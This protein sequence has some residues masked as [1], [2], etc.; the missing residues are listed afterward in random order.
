MKEL[1]VNGNRSI[2]EVNVSEAKSQKSKSGKHQIVLKDGETAVFFTDNKEGYGLATR[3][4]KISANSPIIGARLFVDVTKGENGI[5][6]ANAFSFGRNIFTIKGNN[7]AA[8]DEYVFVGYPFKPK[9]WGENNKNFS[10]CMFVEEWDAVAKARVTNRYELSFTRASENARKLLS[11]YKGLAAIHATNLKK[12]PGGKD[13]DGKEVV[14][15]SAYADEV[16]LI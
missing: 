12:T 13:K 6:M 7:E 15:Y 4:D 9:D 2:I 16:T 1:Y 14:Y 10:I 11:E 5:L 8:K 3:I